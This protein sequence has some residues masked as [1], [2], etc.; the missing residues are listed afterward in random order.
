L[1][2]HALYCACVR[3]KS[4]HVDTGSISCIRRNLPGGFCLPLPGWPFRSSM[5]VDIA[6][7]FVCVET[8]LAL[9]YFGCVIG[10]QFLLR[11]FTGGS[12]LAIVASTLAIAIL[13]HPLRG[14][15][16]S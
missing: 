10:L 4:S 8:R 13:F 7:S 12:E 9:V 6:H 2:G 14:V 5:V 3:G 1:D 15:D 16:C 11:G